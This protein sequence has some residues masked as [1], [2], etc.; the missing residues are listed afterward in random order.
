MAARTSSRLPCLSMSK[1]TCLPGRSLKWPERVRRKALKC[2]PQNLTKLLQF[3]FDIRSAKA[4]D[5]FDT[6]PV[7]GCVS[8]VKGMQPLS[9]GMTTKLLTL[10]VVELRPLPRSIKQRD[11]GVD[12][13]DVAP[14]QFIPC[15]TMNQWAKIG[16]G[17]IRDADHAR[18]QVVESVFQPFVVAFSGVATNG[19]QECVGREFNPP[20]STLILAKLQALLPYIQMMLH[21]VRAT[22]YEHFDAIDGCNVPLECIRSPLFGGYTK[23]RRP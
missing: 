14:C 13:D 11:L 8:G 6:V 20:P 4:S 19:F 10:H 1:V 7:G 12:L 18:C 23:K 17:S 2:A 15:S 22:S 9:K 3:T 5:R 16:L 21:K